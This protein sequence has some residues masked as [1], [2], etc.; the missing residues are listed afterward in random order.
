M[1][2]GW[3]WGLS[4]YV[5]N[6]YYYHHHFGVFL[7]VSFTTLIIFTHCSSLAMFLCSPCPSHTTWLSSLPP[8]L[9]LTHSQTH[10]QT[11]VIRMRNQNIYIYSSLITFTIPFCSALLPGMW[12][13]RQ[14]ATTIILGACAPILILCPISGIVSP[15][16]GHGY[17]G[18]RQ[19]F[20]GIFLNEEWDSW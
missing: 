15:L 7:F 13:K 5:F 20:L 18:F 3:G 16:W 2:W 9:S 1:G 10:S 8:S 11:E 14:A 12:P 6:Y 4:H 17:V 19:G